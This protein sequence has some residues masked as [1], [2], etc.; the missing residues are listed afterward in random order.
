MGVLPDRCPATRR[1]PMVRTRALR[2]ALGRRF[3]ISPGL[4]RAQMMEAAAAGKLKALYVVGANPVKTFGVA[5]ADARRPRFAG[6]ARHVPHRNRAA[7]RRGSARRVGLRKRRHAD[8][9]RRRSA[10][11][12]IAR[13]SAG[14]RSDFD[15]I[16]ILSHQLGMLGLARRSSCAQR[17]RPSTK[18]ASTWRATIFRMPL[19]GGRREIATA[20]GERGI[21]L[22]RSAGAIFSSNDSLFTSGTLGRYCSKLDSTN[23]AKEKP[24]SREE[25]AA[26]H[27]IL[28]VSLVKIAVLLFVV[29]TALA[30][31]TWFER[32]VVAHIQSRWGPYYV[33]PHGLLQPLADGV[34]FLFKEDVTPPRRT[35]S[36]ICSRRFWRFRSRLRDCADSLWAAE[37]TVLGQPIFVVANVDIG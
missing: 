11:C 4:Q 2:Q 28:V 18:F 14:P 9:H 24:W 29:M 1:S 25:F 30:Y 34:K 6:R 5:Q 12:R 10:A 3:P 19:A 8:E 22:R 35:N 7:R 36:S 31:L 27:P 23:E 37:L 26:Q 33:G 20:N 13:R 32:K 17:K 21:G 15:F 16:R